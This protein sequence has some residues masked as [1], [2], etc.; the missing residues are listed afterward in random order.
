ML[1]VEQAQ[2]EPI[3]SSPGTLLELNNT[4]ATRQGVASP[5]PWPQSWVEWDWTIAQMQLG[6]L[7]APSGQLN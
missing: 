4:G 3:S 6:A 2:N 7:G 5:G 1:A